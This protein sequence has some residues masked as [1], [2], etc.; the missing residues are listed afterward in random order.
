MPSAECRCT[1]AIEGLEECDVLAG[2]DDEVGRRANKKN[3]KPNEGGNCNWPRNRNA[4][5]VENLR[6]NSAA[7]G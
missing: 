2:S 6:D 3:E 1:A 5:R 7:E 4:E